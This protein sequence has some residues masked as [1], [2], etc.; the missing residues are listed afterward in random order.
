[1]KEPSV[2]FATVNGIRSRYCGSPKTYV[3]E[4]CLWAE[5]RPLHILEAV[6]RVR[7]YFPD[8]SEGNVASV[9]ATMAAAGRLVRIERGVY[10]HPKLG[11]IFS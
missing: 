3:I 7:D 4:Y 1:M 6:R 11:D 8:V 5:R 10:A 2:R 9:L